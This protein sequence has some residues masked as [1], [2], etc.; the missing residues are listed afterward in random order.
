[1]FKQVAHVERVERG[2]C[3]CGIQVCG[4]ANFCYAAPPIQLT[5]DRHQ[6][7]RTVMSAQLLIPRTPD[8]DNSVAL[9]G[10]RETAANPKSI[11]K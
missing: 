3:Y 7:S 8:E 6:Y 11:L 5:Y 1:M 10:D 2:R 4:R 9:E